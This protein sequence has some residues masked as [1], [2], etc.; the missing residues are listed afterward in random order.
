MGK[1]SIRDLRYDFP[2]IRRLLR[3]GESIEIT[4]RGKVIGCLLP[5]GNGAGKWPDFEARWR[6]RFGDRILEPTGAELLRQERDRY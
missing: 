3:R 6:A 4:D 5:A 1:A 2:R